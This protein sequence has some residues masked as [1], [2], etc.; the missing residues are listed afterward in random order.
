[1]KFAKKEE[2]T[3]QVINEI[4]LLVEFHNL[5]EQKQK[6]EFLLNGGTTED[7]VKHLIKNT[8]EKSKLDRNEYDILVREMKE[9]DDLEKMRENKQ[10][11]SITIELFP[12][13]HFSV[14][15]EKIDSFYEILSIDSY[16]LIKRLDFFFDNGIIPV[17][18]ILNENIIQEGY[19][20]GNLDDKGIVSWRRIRVIR[21]KLYN[22]EMKRQEIKYGL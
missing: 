18:N 22:E 15:K 4:Q 7:K 17:L 5:K 21:E 13:G 11:D 2:E 9:F 8:V 16:K 20:N 1:L 19:M 3:Q 10:K 6:L 12:I 14:P